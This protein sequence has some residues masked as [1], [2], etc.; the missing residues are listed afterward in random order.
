[1]SGEPNT[2]GFYS[3]SHPKEPEVGGFSASLAGPSNPRESA[4]LIEM[5]DETPGDEHSAGWLSIGPCQSMLF[6]PVA[7]W[8]VRFSRKK[9]AEVVAECMIRSGIIKVGE[10]HR[11]R[12]CEH[13]WDSPPKDED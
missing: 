3:T 6:A 9:D 12:A 1:M 2:Q 7:S 13:V 10:G 8:A 4:W 5:W 11:I